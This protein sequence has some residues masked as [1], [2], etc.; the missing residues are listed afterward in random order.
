VRI[1]PGRNG[2]GRVVI[3]YSSLD[4]LDGILAKLRG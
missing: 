3:G 2:A 4:E 1:E